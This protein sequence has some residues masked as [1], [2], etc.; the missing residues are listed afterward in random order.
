M[1]ASDR[2]D[3]RRQLLVI[4]GRLLNRCRG[5]HQDEFRAPSYGLRVPEVIG[6]ADPVRG[7]G[8]I[9]YQTAR[10]RLQSLGTLIVGKGPL[11]QGNAPE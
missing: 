4:E 6:F 9:D 1:P 3:G 5:V 7:T 8:L 11:G 10:P 2:I